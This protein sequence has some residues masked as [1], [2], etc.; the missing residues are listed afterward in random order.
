MTREQLIEKI[1]MEI[2]VK[3]NPNDVVQDIIR[4]IL[5]IGYDVEINIT[6]LF[7]KLNPK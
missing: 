4:N 1:M 5:N 3:S 7:K 6:E 2:I